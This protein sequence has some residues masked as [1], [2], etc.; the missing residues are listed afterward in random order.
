MKQNLNKEFTYHS[1]QSPINK[2]PNFTK[3]MKMKWNSKSPKNR[4]NSPAWRE[5]NPNKLS[6][7]IIH[8]NLN[9]ARNIDDVKKKLLSYKAPIRLNNK[10]FKK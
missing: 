5:V 6:K 1:S 9:T 7:E 4:S 8:S 2:N 3:L 10:Y